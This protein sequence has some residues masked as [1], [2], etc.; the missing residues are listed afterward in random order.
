MTYRKYREN[1]AVGCLFE[2]NADIIT[3]IASIA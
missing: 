1:A 3:A 2:E